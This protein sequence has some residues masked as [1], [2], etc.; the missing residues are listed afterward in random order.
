[1]DHTTSHNKRNVPTAKV[2]TLVVG[3]I[4]LLS[5]G[6]FGGIQYQ[7]GKGNNTLASNDG[8]QQQFPGSADGSFG[9]GSGMGNMG[10]GM[11]GG[12]GEVTA[13][14]TSNI[15]VKNS[16]S[17]SS[18]T[19]SIT[20]STKVTNGQTAASVSDIAVGDTVIVQTDSSDAKQAS[21]IILNPQMGGGP[22][23]GNSGGSL[24][25]QTN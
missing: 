22:T 19:Y 15:T 10:R 21:S 8:N 14:T 12:F 24:D 7:K 25:V 3:G 1:M 17:G 20:S 18:T 13:V 23:G 2:T 5:L 9:N 4:V 6:F 16:R 11:P